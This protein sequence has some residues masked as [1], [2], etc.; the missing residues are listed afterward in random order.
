MFLLCFYQ[1]LPDGGN[2]RLQDEYIV[3]IQQFTHFTDGMGEAVRWRREGIRE[4]IWL[5][6]RNIC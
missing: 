1:W 6:K 5:K 4:A 2:G 3:Y